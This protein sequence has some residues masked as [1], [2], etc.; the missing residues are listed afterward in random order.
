[1]LKVTGAKP[2]IITTESRGRVAKGWKTTPLTATGSTGGAS[3]AKPVVATGDSDEV[4]ALT[5]Q[6]LGTRGRFLNTPGRQL[7]QLN[8][9]CALNFVFQT[10]KQ[11]R[12]V[13][14]SSDWAS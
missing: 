9:L 2:K 11:Y 13:V 5:V 1:M 10:L 7:C 12:R 8:S 6:S 3:G 14:F 4:I